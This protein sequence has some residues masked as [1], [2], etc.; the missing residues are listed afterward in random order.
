MGR[1]SRKIMKKTRLERLEVHINRL[2]QFNTNAMHEVGKLAVA[3]RAY[4]DPKAW[5]GDFDK[6]GKPIVIWKLKEDGPQIAR[7]VLTSLGLPWDQ[8]P[9]KVVQGGRE[10]V[11]KSLAVDMKQ[12]R[13]GKEEDDRGDPHKQLLQDLDAQYDSNGDPKAEYGRY[14]AEGEPVKI[15]T[16]AEDE[17]KDKVGAWPTEDD[18]IPPEERK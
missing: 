8:M 14:N 13:E 5:E 17:T 2:G 6:E 11:L 7:D 10:S 12:E 1:A 18:S 16:E 4:A 9:E 15:Q 3:L